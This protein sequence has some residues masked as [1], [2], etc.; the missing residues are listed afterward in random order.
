MSELL[1]RLPWRQFLI[2][3]VSAAAAVTVAVAF[4]STHYEHPISP[5]V[6]VFPFIAAVI[7]ATGGLVFRSVTGREV[8]FNP[9]DSRA[10]DRAIIHGF[11]G[12]VSIVLFQLL[13]PV[14]PVTVSHVAAAASVITLSVIVQPLIR[15]CRQKI[16]A[17][18]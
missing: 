3:V 2:P 16:S 6:I 8:G 18:T 15:L 12:Y 14:L 13:R 5:H 1:G 10:V 9:Q 4:V 7:G 17:Q 11:A